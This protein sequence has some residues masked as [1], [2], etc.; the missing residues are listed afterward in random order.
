MYEGDAHMRA[1]EI[2]NLLS[3][4]AESVVTMLLPSGKRKVSVQADGTAG[5]APGGQNR[6]RHFCK[7]GAALGCCDVAWQV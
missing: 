3:T 4:N 5:S 7:T 2:S 6:R 1:T